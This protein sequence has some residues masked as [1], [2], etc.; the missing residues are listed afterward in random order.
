L[1]EVRKGGMTRAT[2]VVVIYVSEPEARRHN[3]RP[4][5]F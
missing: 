5:P 3:P 1:T 2:T 4:G